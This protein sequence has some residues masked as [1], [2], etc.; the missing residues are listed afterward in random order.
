MSLSA[1]SIGLF[2]SFTSYIIQNSI[3]VSECIHCI[4]DL[5]IAK[6]RDDSEIATDA[7]LI[8]WGCVIRQNHVLWL[9]DHWLARCYKSAKIAANKMC[10]NADPMVYMVEH[11]SDIDSALSIATMPPFVSG[12]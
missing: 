1:V 4:I 9:C 2:T 6:K 3:E 12:Q 10:Q 8:L 11:I 7:M 5:P